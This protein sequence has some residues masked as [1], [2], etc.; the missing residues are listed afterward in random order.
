VNKELCYRPDTLQAETAWTLTVSQDNRIAQMRRAEFAARRIAIQGANAAL[1]RM[2]LECPAF[3]PRY[4]PIF[5]NLPNRTERRRPMPQYVLKVI[6]D[7]EARDD[8][9]ARQRVGELVRA[10]VQP[11]PGV[12]EIV[13]HA[14]A[15]NKSIRVEPDGTFPGNWNKGGPGQPVGPRD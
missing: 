10:H 4:T 15:D 5:P 6:L 7:L 1:G 11:L 14:K 12:R 8:L 2:N 3:P 13:L 9:D